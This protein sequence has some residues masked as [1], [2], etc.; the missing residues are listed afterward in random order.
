MRVHNAHLFHKRFDSMLKRFFPALFI[1]LAFTVAAPAQEVEVDRYNIN[2]RIDTA[3]SA[4][5][6][7]A[8]LA[9]SNLGQSSKPK[10]YLRLTRLA[11]VSTVTVN[12]AA[13]KFETVEDKRVTTLNQI[14]I[15]PQSPIEAGTKAT[16]EVSYRIEAPESTPLIHIYPGE[17]LLTPGAVWVPMPSTMFAPIYGPTTAPIILTV[18]A[19]SPAANFQALSSGTLKTEGQ[20]SIFEQ[21]LN[22]LPLVVA[23]SFDQPVSS[24]R[25]GVR[26][27]IFVQS[28]IVAVPMDTKLAD[29][30]A[31]IA[32]LGDEA[33]TVIEL[34]TRT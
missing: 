16:V 22:S 33:R 28:G 10:L 25:G 31:I 5:D 2:A 17:V 20:N 9:I 21:P 1:V 13:A 12:G 14:V 6:V 11:K 27:E 19:V 26:V 8:T 29:P 32:R 30:R 4:V 7:R 18:S 34:V 3:A 24:D 15:T 23:G